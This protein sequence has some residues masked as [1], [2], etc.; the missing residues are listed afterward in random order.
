[1]GPL[2]Y[3]SYS[4]RSA[5]V[6]GPYLNNKEVGALGN[7]SSL[8]LADRELSDLQL[9]WHQGPGYAGYVVVDV[10]LRCFT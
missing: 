9:Q 10:D 3:Y 5:G 7:P 2:I 4:N 1:M 6:E 8:V